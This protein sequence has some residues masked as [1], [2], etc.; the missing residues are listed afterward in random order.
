M[1]EASVKNLKKGEYFKLKAPEQ[2]PVW[3]RGDYVREAKA[4]SCTKF[5]DANHE[6][7]F[8]GSKIIITEFTF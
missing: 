3:V 6:R 7:L 8:F 1:I 5:D 2:S 4:Y